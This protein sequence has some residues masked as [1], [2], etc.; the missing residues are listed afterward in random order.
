MS[1]EPGAGGS[2]AHAGIGFQD[3]VAAWVAVRILAEAAA[4]WD[5]SS[6]VTLEF[7][8]CNTEQPVDDL[9]VGTSE[10]GVVLA[11]VKHRLNL[12]SDPN[13][14]LASALDQFVRQFLLCQRTAG[15][16]PWEHVLEA[17]RDR[18][19]LLV[20]PRSS[21][22]IRY[23]LPSVLERMRSLTES[24][25]LGDAAT[26]DRE[27]RVLE[28]VWR[29]VERSWTTASGSTPSETDLRALLSLVRVQTLDVDAGGQDELSAKDLLCSSVLRN[30]EQADAAWTIL[31][32]TCAG[33]AAN[34]S[35][36]GRGELQNALL[37]ADIRIPVKPPRSYSRDIQSLRQYSASQIRRLSRFS[38]INTESVQ[39]KVTRACQEPLREAAEE[40]SLLVL[41]EPGAGKSGVLVDLARA[42][43]HEDKDVIFLPAADL[44]TRNLA[45]LGA[46][47][48]LEHNLV[49]VLS[50][51]PGTE[52]GFL[53][54]DALD[55]ARSDCAASVLDELIDGV[56]RS[57][58]RW[59][60]VASVRKFDL[61]Y[62]KRVREL[63]AGT[64]PTDFVDVEFSN[65]RHVNV[66][67]LGEDELGQIATQSP[68]L[69]GLI[70]LIPKQLRS[71]LFNISLL[72]EVLTSGVRPEAL[73]P[74][75]TQVDLLDLYWRERVLGS[76]PQSDAREAILRRVTEAMVRERLLYTSRRAAAEDP[77]ASP[78]LNELLSRG[79][80]TEW[81]PSPE[82]APD[83]YIL[84]FGHH[85]MFDY[86][87]ARL[88][89]RG[90]RDEP[91]ELICWLRSEP[92][93]VLAIR[94]SFTFHF[95]YLWA[96][97]T[98]RRRFWRVTIRLVGADGIPETAKLVGPTVAADQVSDA[99]DFAPLLAALSGQDEFEREAVERTF[100][101]LV[102]AVLTE[103]PGGLDGNMSPW[104][105]LVESVSQDLRPAIGHAAA[106]L[107]IRLTEA[108]K[109]LTEE[110]T[111][112]CGTAARALL[113]FAW[114]QAPRDSWL[115]TISLQVVCRTFASDPDAS[116]S[117][118]RRCI[119]LPHLRQHG[120]EELR[121]VA[122][123]MQ[124]VI[125]LDP[126]LAEE[127][128]KASFQW[129]YSADLRQLRVTPT[130]MGTSQILPLISNQLQDLQ[131]ALRALA[132]AYP[133]FLERAPVN[134]VRALVAV[135][136]AY[137][138]KRHSQST[139]EGAETT[140]CF[141]GIAARIETDYSSIWDARGAYSHDEPIAL[142][143]ALEKRLE[144]LAQ[145]DEHA[146]CRR[147]IVAVVAQHNRF[148]VVWRRIL[149]VATKHPGTV[150][151]DVRALAWAVP[152]LTC[153][154]TTVPAGVYLKAVFPLLKPRERAR[155]EGAIISIPEAERK[156][157]RLLG[158]LPLDK[159]VTDDAK[160]A[161][162]DLLTR[163]AVPKNKPPFRFDGP[164]CSAYGEEEYLV[165]QGVP[166][167]QDQN[168]GIR[169]LEEPVKEFTKKNLNGT[170]SEDEIAGVLPHLKA[171]RQALSTAEADGVHPEQQDYAWG[172]LAE[173]CERI[174]R[175]DELSCEHELGSFVK[176]V[177][178]EASRN[179]VP[180]YDADSE[181][182]FDEASSWGGPSARIEA[183]AGLT[184][185]MRHPSCHGDEVREAVE[186]LAGDRVSAVRYQVARR[187]NALCRAAPDL[188]WRLAEHICRGESSRSALQG[189]LG[190]PM[191]RLAG[192]HPDQVVP[193]VKEVYKRMR[194]DPKASGVRQACI[195][196][197]LRLYLWQ[198]HRA[199][200]SAIQEIVEDPLT[201][202]GEAR[203]VAAN[204]RDVLTIG[205]VS[206][207]D[208]RQDAVRKRAFDL[209]QTI[210]TR[211]LET[212]DA[213][214]GRQRG[215]GGGELA[216]SDLE[217]I[218]HCLELADDVCHQLYFASGAFDE[219][220]RDPGRKVLDN[221]K[222]QRFY[223]EALPVID[224]LIK[225]A[226]PAVVHV[227]VETLASLI[228]VDPEG[229][230][231]RIGRAV[232]TG[233][234]AGYQYESLAVQLVVA[235]VE[236]YLAEYRHIFRKHSECRKALLDVL[237][238]FVRV[239]WPAARKLTYRLEEI[240]R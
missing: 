90:D 14:D 12:Q 47:L 6:G 25:S 57:A 8:R 5:L 164:T 94:P 213:L 138:S 174:T 173:A 19:V 178:L 150:G 114:A 23:D 104:C 79:V 237:D 206:P 121:W 176:A 143:N 225:F 222:K 216:Q 169:Q 137:V 211:V 80:L 55:S 56:N 30:P 111:R 48:H 210:V 207:A 140:F 166:I 39:V 35:G 233:A 197:F 1:R 109:A 238:T 74:I 26:N 192:G 93:L 163:D 58:S 67:R 124:H 154:D 170:P 17:G 232:Q 159:L 54:I 75:R 191:D 195:A 43:A 125:P 212:F 229:V 117:L 72:A 181:A 149:R 190:G 105:H 231:L 147:Q 78:A 202:L 179:K 230:F 70:R 85:V 42:L 182:Q 63:F 144:Q 100:Q 33:L 189:L 34:R 60:I 4:P 31:V 77:A 101:H 46:N 156:R 36:A 82:A 71:N 7:L 91:N 102:A 116:A 38:E 177:L 52:P 119:E 115:V 86:A 123:E 73:T 218:Q 186:R 59:R 183:A 10:D 145:T 53:I 65:V 41:G 148:A 132:R 126:Q 200:E 99:G 113:E 134:A 69:A 127:F 203:F 228:P 112:A 118:L 224:R 158:C 83:R 76:D 208:P 49:H 221:G 64:P 165:S 122:E 9:L 21:G 151:L 141:D 22:R 185:L 20:G 215:E 3:R 168:R 196:I 88:L 188:M 235:V 18:L 167:D 155:V 129:Y 171:L 160:A 194:S 89:L 87:V 201:W 37:T 24:Q 214:S 11:Q 128:F 239:G 135:L 29:H 227:L 136:E 157:D 28:T 226:H 120:H 16:K 152:V 15:S 68:E 110:Q 103:P 172:V 146:D 184:Q 92:D 107:L 217:S 62:A 96:A 193:L 27:R 108:G 40:A 130:P 180:A 32:T 139:S 44:D 198:E 236:Q 142:L 61:R 162:S 240:Y 133:Q 153:I 131:S 45:A 106:S 95:Q 81:Q 209:L 205:P 223:E 98:E 13:S 50:N 97:D 66:G 220:Q 204:V 175:L 51:W 234:E 187:L 219:K 84:A 199:C 2:A 161:L